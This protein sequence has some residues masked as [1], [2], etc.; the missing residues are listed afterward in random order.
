MLSTQN[1]TCSYAV[2]FS[3]YATSTASKSSLPAVQ[4]DVVSV[5]KKDRPG[6]DRT[7]AS[8]AM[9]AHEGSTKIEGFIC[10]HSPLVTF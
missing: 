3:R 5:R 10:R 6:Q 9:Q 2:M 4:R 1:L 7:L 8:A